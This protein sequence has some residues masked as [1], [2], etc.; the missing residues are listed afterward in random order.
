MATST[1]RAK[2]GRRAG[3]P[4]GDD[5]DL[6]ARLLDVA[7]AQFARAGIGATSLRAIAGEAEVTPAMLHYYFGDKP[8]LVQALVEERLLPALAPLRVQLERAGDDPRVLIEA[9]VRGIGEVVARHPWLPPLWVREVLCDGG[10]LREVLFTQAV[11]GLPQL[12]ARRFAAAQ[13]D[14]RLNADLDPRLLVVSLVGL[15]L[16]PAAGAPI[17]R[18][19]FGAEGLE[20]AAMSQHTLA[21]LGHGV[22]TRKSGEAA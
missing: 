4:S 22:G 12:L 13:A 15:T 6:R 10:A 5:L 7:I 19:M 11:P 18:R 9:F 3:R 8:R 21:L 16:F 1:K 14:G 17:W 20:S 2:A